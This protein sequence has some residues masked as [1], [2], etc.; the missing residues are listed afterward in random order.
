ML[1]RS[2]S[3]VESNPT[4]SGDSGD[5]EEGSEL[6]KLF[7]L[8]PDCRMTSILQE[9]LYKRDQVITRLAER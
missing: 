9:A 1:Q 7:Q 8:R 3:K 5:V 4:Q 2:R 6:E